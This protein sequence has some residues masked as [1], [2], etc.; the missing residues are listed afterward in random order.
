MT[1]PPDPSTDVTLTITEQPWGT[2]HR[3]SCTGCTYYRYW[4]SPHAAEND[5]LTHECTPGM[6]HQARAEAGTE[7]QAGQ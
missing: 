1:S 3:V 2:E 4:A 6:Q 7:P 5:Q